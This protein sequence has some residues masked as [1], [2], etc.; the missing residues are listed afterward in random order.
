MY[1]LWKDNVYITCKYHSNLQLF[2]HANLWTLSSFVDNGELQPPLPETSSRT[3]RW[4]TTKQKLSR[5]RPYLEW[6]QHDRP[7]AQRL[8]HQGA[9]STQRFLLQAQSPLVCVSCPKFTCRWKKL[10]R[11]VHLLP[12]CTTP[13][14]SIHHSQ[15]QIWKGTATPC[16]SI[17]IDHVQVAFGSSG[18]W[19]QMYM[20]GPSMGVDGTQ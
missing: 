7:Q 11:L 6:T 4:T 15:N 13:L 17:L 19:A 8:L 5:H 20:Y 9:S 10:L 12:W 1:I 16:I 14:T 18:V 2:Q 3:H